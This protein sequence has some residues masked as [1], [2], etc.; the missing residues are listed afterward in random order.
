[1]RLSYARS[2]VEQADETQNIALAC[3]LKSN[4]GGP[5]Q[6]ALK[7]CLRHPAWATKDYIKQHRELPKQLDV[8]AH[9]HIRPI[10]EIFATG[11]PTLTDSAFQTFTLILI[12]TPR[13]RP[14]HKT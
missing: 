2:R 5:V 8:Y 1:M 3:Q 9:E 12:V 7:I 11:P 14:S 13:P 4:S 10:F 6:S